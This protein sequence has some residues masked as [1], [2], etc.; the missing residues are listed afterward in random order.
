MFRQTKHS[1]DMRCRRLVVGLLVSTLSLFALAPS[2]ATAVPAGTIIENRAEATY[3]NDRI[4][5]IETIRS[6]IVSAQVLPVPALEVSGGQI[7][8]LARSSTNQ[9]NFRAENIGNIALD[10]SFGTEELL[11]DDFDV[12]GALHVDSNSNGTIDSGDYPI[13]GEQKVTLEIGEQV[14]L[15]YTFRTPATVDEDDVAETEL[16]TTATPVQGATSIPFST[17]P[18]VETLQSRA[19]IEDAGLLLL[20]SAAMRSD[21]GEIEYRIIARNNAETPLVS[22][23]QI[24]DQSV[25]VDGVVRDAI[26]VRD[27]IPLNTTIKSAEDGGAFEAVYHLRGAATHSYTQTLPTDL[28]SVDAV[29][30]IHDGDYA[31]GRS[32][33]LA[34]TVTIS[35]TIEDQDIVNTAQ[36]YT[37]N[38][39]GTVIRDSNMVITPVVGPGQTIDFISVPGGPPIESTSFDTNV[40]IT[41]GAGSC[42]ISDAIDEVSVVVTTASLGDREV[43][44]ARETGA[45]TGIF[46]TT[47]IGVIRAN[48]AT[49]LNSVLE[50]LPGDNATAGAT[51]TCLGSTLT[52]SIGLQP[53]GFVFD[54]VTNESVSGA[55]VVV[56][57]LGGIAGTTNEFPFE[58]S[59]F[60][61]GTVDVDFSGGAISE[62]MTDAQGY[63]DLGD[64]PKGDYRL[65]IFPPSSYVFPSVRQT[66][67]GFDRRV[68][69][70]VSYGT[71]FTFAG[72][73]MANIDVPLDPAVGI[74]LTIAKTSDRQT[75]RRGGFVIYT[76][77]ANNQMDQALLNAEIIDQ[78]PP[79]LLFIEGSARRDGENFAVA[80]T[81]TASGELTFDLDVVGPNTSTEI[82]YAVRIGTAARAGDKTNVAMLR[83]Q[84]AGT[85]SSFV[86]PQGR[87]TIT[88]DDRGGV[89][90]DEAV[91]IGRVFLDKNGDGIQ[92]AHDEDGNPHNEPGVP[93]VKIV[94]SDGLSVVTD[95]EGRYSL[96]GLRPTTAAIAVQSSTLPKSAVHLELDVDDV[97]APGSRF[98]DLKRGELRAEQF[99]LVWSPEAEADVAER[100]Q[101]FEGLDPDESL[102]RDD[103][104]L[105]FD[106]VTRK[107]SRNETGIDTKTELLTETVLREAAG[108]EGNDETVKTPIEVLVKEL[109]PDLAFVGI[110]D[111]HETGRRSI[112]V[113]VKGPTKG[114]LRLEVNGEKIPESQIGAKAIH[115]DGGVQVYEY[116][117]LRLAPNENTITAIVTDPFGNDRGREEISVFA[118]GDP[119][120]IVVVVPNEAKADS[121]ARI[122]VVVRIVDKAGRLVRVPADVTLSAENG[123]WDVRDIRDSTYGLQAYID[124]GEATFDFIPPDLVGS[125][126]IGIETN[127]ASVEAEIGFTPDLKERTFVGVVEGAIRFGEDGNEIEGLLSD[128]EI[129][130]F[131]ETTEGVRG[132]L[133]LKGKILGENLLT[134]RYNSD[135]DTSERL[136]RDIRRDEFYP[137]YGDNSERGFDAQSS[138]S[139]YVKVEREQSYILYGDIAVEP[140]ADAIRLGAYRRSLTGGRAHIEHGPVT[141]DL[142]VAETDEQQQ[143]VEQRGRGVSGPYDFDFAGLTE[144][145]EVVEI[146]TRDRDQPDVIISK[147]TQTRLSDYTVDFFDGSLIFNR[148]IPLLDENLNPVS[149]RVTFETE[150]GAGDDY[151]VYGGEIRIEPIEGVAV[152]Y[153]EIRSD[154]SRDLDDRRTVRSAYIEAGTDKFGHAQVEVAQTENRLDERGEGIRASYEYHGDKHVIRAEAA[155]TDEEFDAPNSYVSAGREEVR[156]TTDHKITDAASVSTDSLYTRDI[157]TD[158]RRIGTEIKGR[159]RVSP[160]LDVVAGGRA[161]ETRRSNGDRDEVYSGIVGVDWRPDFLPRSS[162]HAEFEQDF[163]EYENWRLTVG[164]DYQWNPNLRLYALN[165]IS[166]TESGFFGLGDGGNAN[167]TTKVGAEYQLNENISGFSE[168]RE[169]AGLSGDDGAATGIKGQWQLTE[170]LAMR[171]SAEHVEALNGEDDRSSAATLGVT[172][173][174]DEKGLILRNDLEADRDDDGLGLFAN[175]AIGYELNKDLTVLARNRLAYDLRGDNRLRDRLR[176]GLA[177][178]PEH[179]SRFKALALY[180]FEIDDEP[181]LREV[182]HRWSF[183]G[184]YHPTDD[185]RMNAK[186]AGEYADIEGP[187]FSADSMLHLVRAGAEMDFG[188]NFD[189]EFFGGNR[190]AIGGHVSAFTDN[191]GEDVTLGVGVELKANVVK[192][193]QVGIGYNYIDVEEDRLRDLYQS[194][195]FA[196]VRIKL[197]DSIWDQFDNVG[198]TTG[199]ESAE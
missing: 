30:F 21:A 177:Y 165:E 181:D 3:F 168:Y 44:I 144:G 137:V 154:A 72:G 97:H 171:M 14:S 98:I 110:E 59:A 51:A 28:S 186:Y 68:D 119:A 169:S 32:S 75:V 166:S 174:N 120:N 175:T 10:T 125:E 152:G 121:R 155:R 176:F 143:V 13:S 163:K 161:V 99:P 164:A 55:R 185:L 54:S 11:G 39:A 142:F 64:I 95:S 6:N 135:Y 102:L 117:A 149:I 79:G 140:Q 56:F 180:E 5:T 156:V 129:S 160:S 82:T 173:E 93:G 112:A 107:S 116:V 38:G 77:T 145:S 25:L 84:Q 178:R 114:K 67:D 80:P 53:G 141:V 2:H 19:I 148:P 34:F 132:Q 35:P 62:S 86:S 159:Y 101:R 133:Y 150:E 126:T 24:D 189:D 74:P 90:A 139:L 170:H 9:Y 196:R 130:S 94:T 87:S 15:I 111:G 81:L 153:R 187:G 113:R 123:S 162:V 12:V 103:L 52:T 158:E 100:I 115:R 26:L 172:Y 89:F 190:F 78:L 73:P 199:F 41:V 146:I 58:R 18:L 197:D 33:D 20:K 83:G 85:G 46:E 60:A 31:V 134:L 192:N 40:L 45:N 36:G 194:G 23:E 118:P 124:N 29:A 96:I 43:L 65:E 147:L 71:N 198:L 191:D 167:F 37:V 57:S 61:T 7:L 70:Q 42:N 48:V 131:E 16:T 195:F 193:V 109:D 128:D 106:A 27:L 182:A 8:H 91:V 179:D 47:P 92:T 188:L 127:F 183:S 108:D 138:S 76:L 122:P 105:T 184:T 69:Q 151:F 63:F 49:Q 1:I 4:G 66:F 50:G 104:P 157:E 17:E 22:Y 88:V 136:F